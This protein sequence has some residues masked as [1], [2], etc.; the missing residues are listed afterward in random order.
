MK[1]WLLYSLITA[2]FWGLWGI[3]AKLASRS[4]GSRNLLLLG[5][6]G[7]ILAFPV[8]L[9]MFHKQLKFDWT[10]INFYYALLGGV[11]GSIGCLFFYQALARGEASKVV[12]MTAMYPA[13]TVVLSILV[14]AEKPTIYKIAGICCALMSIYFLSK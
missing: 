13:I 14:L 7:S 2:F 4:M 6:M 3:F 8:F 12:V 1:P 5:T 10:S 11:I 9:A